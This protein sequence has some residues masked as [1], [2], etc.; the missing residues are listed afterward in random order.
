[1]SPVNL[2]KNMFRII[3]SICCQIILFYLG[4]AP[5]QFIA[6]CEDGRSK[7]TI[8]ERVFTQ[9]CDTKRH[10]LSKHSDIEQHASCSYCGK[11]FKTK[12][13]LGNHTR[14]VHSVYK[15]NANQY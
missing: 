6:T 13:S 8:C 11:T 4:F 10:I 14:L 15:N 12:Q 9:K 1:M 5:E 3:I 2:A 7:C